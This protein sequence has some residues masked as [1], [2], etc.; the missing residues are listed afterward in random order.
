MS[1][2]VVANVLIMVGLINVLYRFQ[3][4]FMPFTRR[5]FIALGMGVA[6]GALIQM[7]YGVESSVVAQ[8]I[9]WF[10]IVGRGYVALLRMIIV[11]LV[12]VSVISSILRLKDA[13][14]LGRIS[15]WILGLLMIT[16]SVS[17]IIGVLASLGFG[18]SAEAITSGAREA[19]RGEAIL[20]RASEIQSLSIPNMLISLVP[21]NPFLDMTGARSTSIIGV[22]IFSAFIGVSALGLN[23]KKPEVFATIE[24][25]VNV[26]HALVMRMVTLVLRL[27]PFGI[28]ALMTKVV[29]GSNFADIMQLFN[30]V[31]ASYV[32]LIAVFVVH[33]LMVA[34]VGGSP[35]TFLKKVLPVLTF[36][37]TSRSS[38]GTMPLTIQTMTK[39]L[40]VSETVANFSA[41]FGTTI[42]QNGC[43]GIYPAMLAVMIAPTVGVDPTSLS[44]IGTLVVTIAIGSFGVAG[45][46]GGATF[47]ALIVLSALGLPVELAGLLISIE[48]LIDMGRTAVNVS[49][50]IATGF[51]GGRA[52][53]EVDMETFN[54]NDSFELDMEAVS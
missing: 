27:T 40:G 35:I 49:G 21:F 28:L 30:F 19:A 51:V 12:M 31:A 23:R 54:A 26:L 3:K 2:A 44:F 8:S 24:N 7:I 25:S 48:P 36:A 45:V 37:F 32:A 6:F 22:V 38:A 5:V 18:L 20:S 16:V 17:A 33:L 4:Q 50:A 11:P 34:F 52:M 39:R 47:A 29:A 46:G 13:G 41:S 15:G 42:G 14:S 53:G 9:N 43:A 10:D 1:F